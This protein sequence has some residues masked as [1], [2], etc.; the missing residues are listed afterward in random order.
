VASALAPRSTTDTSPSVRT[1]TSELRLQR[2][3][4][5]VQRGHGGTC[6]HPHTA[7]LEEIPGEPDIERVQFD[8]VP[9]CANIDLRNSDNKA[10]H[11]FSSN[12]FYI[13][14]NNL[15]QVPKEMKKNVCHI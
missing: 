7:E 15:T 9:I 2:H 3:S 5:V 10:V 1:E 12:L 4:P 6:H 13:P 11:G 14:V 8:P